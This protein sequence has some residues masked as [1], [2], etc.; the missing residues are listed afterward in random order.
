MMRLLRWTCLSL[1]ILAGARPAQ[2]CTIPVFRYAFERWDLS[3]YELVVFHRD[4][5]SKDAHAAI[6]SVPSHANLVVTT[7]DLNGKVSPALRKLWERQGAAATLPH[8]VLRRPGAGSKAAWSGPLEAASLR[9]L[10]DSPARRN[11]VKALSQGDAG[12]F[13]V[14]LSGDRA[15]DAAVTALVRRELDKLEKLV[16]LPEQR[17]DGPRIKLALPLKVGFT[18]LPLKRDEPGED[19]LVQLLLTSENDLP[20][21]SGPIVFAVFGRGRLLNGM[22]GKDLDNGNLLYEVVSFLCGECSCQVKELNP[23]IDLPIA[24]DWAAIF[25]RIG[26]APDTGPETPLDATRNAARA[27]PLAGPLAIVSGASKPAGEAVRVAVSYYPPI[28]PQFAPTKDA[29]LVVS[30]A[31]HRGWLWDATIAASLMVLVTGAWACVVWFRGG[32]RP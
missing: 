6:G 18:V 5:L 29:Q 25:A 27:K 8:V 17:G 20:R 14:L 7:V 31:P 24:A 28:A 2:A 4:A 26:P 9:R 1:L 10:I 13:V 22:Y 3:P 16:K 19:A 15:A 30:D 23:G 32:P 21:V 11:I 12:V